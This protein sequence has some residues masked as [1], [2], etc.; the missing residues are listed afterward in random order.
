MN[1][2]KTLRK[3]AAAVLGTALTTLLTVGVLGTSGAG[4][5]SLVSVS[6]GT[7]PWIGYAPWYIAQQEGY[8]TK[9]GLKVNIVNFEEDADRNAAL[10][11]GQDRRFQH[12]HGQDRPVRQYQGACR[13][14]FARGRLERRG[15]HNVGQVHL[16]GGAAE[17]PD[18]L[19]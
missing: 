5:S 17:G 18:G 2:W 1:Q 15:R 10:V 3:A 14:S 7:E 12:R 11:A 8:F 6:M 19:V 9:Y 13:P 4:A 16:F